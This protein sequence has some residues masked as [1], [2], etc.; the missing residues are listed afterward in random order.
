MTDDEKIEAEVARIL[1]LPDDEQVEQIVS[2]INALPPDRRDQIFA[3]MRA[4]R[5][6]VTPRARVIANRV[7]G[8]W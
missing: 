5:S 6:G 8:E 1:S 7:R 3:H 2:L 4:D